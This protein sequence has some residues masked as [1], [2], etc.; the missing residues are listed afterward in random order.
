N[1]ALA[2]PLLDFSSIRVPEISNTRPQPIANIQNPRGEDDPALIRN[3]FLANP[4][5]LALLKQNNPRLADALLSGNL[6]RFSTVL[7]EQIAAREERQAQRLRMMNADPFDTEAQR[8][9]AEEIR[10]KNIEA[11]MEAAMEYNPETFGTVVMLYINCKVNGFPVKAFIDSGAQTTIMS[12]ACA[13]RCHIMRL[14]D[15]RWAGVAKGVGVQRIIGRIHMVQIQIGNDHLTTS[16]SVLEEQP[17]DMLLGLDMLKRHQCCI[18][19]KKNVLKIGTTGTETPFLAEGDL[20][21]L[22]IFRGT[23]CNITDLPMNGVWLL[24]VGDLQRALEDS[25]RD[26]K[27]Q[28]QQHDGQ[29]SSNQGSLNRPAALETTVYPHD[30]FTEATVKELEA[31]GFTRAQVIAELRRFSGDKTQ[32][33]AALFAKSL[34]F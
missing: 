1:V 26:A 8:L 11:N 10:Q 33:T 9:I 23:L 21:E 34:K 17:M 25:S 32:A 14:V 16:F 20:P 13:E 5:Q 2:I 24:V 22:Y 30:P 6:D 12:A 31:L 4:D 3:M 19:L 29:G 28:R 27:K 15:T 18:D 7:S